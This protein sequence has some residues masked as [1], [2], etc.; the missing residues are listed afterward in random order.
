MLTMTFGIGIIAAFVGLL[1]LG[2]IAGIATKNKIMSRICGSIL[3]AAAFFVLW[4][5]M[6][7]LAGSGTSRQLF[8]TAILWLAFVICGGLF[9]LCLLLIWK[10]FAVKPRRIG[11]LSLTVVIIIVTGSVM[12]IQGYKN[13]IVELPEGDKEL[14]LIKYAPFGEDTLAASLDEPSTLTLTDNIPRI[15][16][17]TA[18]YPLYSAFVRAT[19]PAGKY[20]VYSTLEDYGLTFDE[21]V[22]KYEFVTEKN[23]EKIRENYARLSPIICNK[24]GGAI[25]NLFSGKADIIFVMD[26]SDEQQRIAD[27]TGLTLTLTP[28]GREA[29]VFLVNSR[30]KIDGLTQDEIRAVYSGRITDWSGIGQGSVSGKIEAYQRPEGSGSQTALQKIMGNTPI[31]EPKDEQVYSMMG[32]LYNAVADYKNYKNALGYSFRFYIESMLNDAEMKKVKL[33]AIDGIS[34]TAQTIADGTYPFADNFYA[35]TVAN[36]EYKSDKDKARAENAQK[37]IDWILSEQ[38]QS[39]VGET[40]Y[41][42]LQD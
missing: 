6:E 16:G 36:R 38:G 29:F 1:L 15:D 9:L 37:L 31:I 18:L 33:L 21:Y 5:F 8:G 24:T 35:V 25:E 32:G 23:S 34:P 14:S 20:D 28:I 22:Q 7:L 41:V 12:G 13:S 27:N 26:I 30:N 19:Y 40:G 2:L 39:L 17:A 10:P 11:A 42:P 3:C 4:L